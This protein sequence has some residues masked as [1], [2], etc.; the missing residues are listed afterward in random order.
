MSD[1]AE[2]LLNLAK[3]LSDGEEVDWNQAEAAAQD[4]EERELL[5]LLRDI[6]QVA[7]VHRTLRREGQPGRSV[8]TT[9][10]VWGRLEVGKKIGQ[11][12]SAEVFR[13][14][15]PQLN[16][17]VA[18]KLFWRGPWMR[19]EDRKSLLLEGQNLARLRH[20]NVV[21]VYGADE[22][23]ERIG[24]WM[25][26][27]E[28]RNLSDI[29]LKQGPHSATEATQ[30]GIELCRAL[31]AVHRKNLVHADIKA[32]N[33]KREEGG[34]IVLMDFSSSRR[35]DG[36]AGNPES[37]PAGTPLYMAPELWENNSPTV[38]S[39]IY[40][41]GVL[42]YH[43]VTGDFPVKAPSIELLQ[44]AHRKQERRLLRDERPELPDSFVRTVEKALSRDPGER[45]RSAGAFEEALRAQQAPVPVKPPPIPIEVR[46][47]AFVARIGISL[48]GVVLFLIAMGFITSNSFNVMLGRPAPFAAESVADWFNWGIKTAIP[49]LIYMAIYA[50][51]ILVLWI[52]WKLLKLASPVA[53]MAARFRSYLLSRVP[54]LGDPVA[55]SRLFFAFGL[56]A[57][58]AVCW[59]YVDLMEAAVTPISEV[60][61]EAVTALDPD[62][63]DTHIAYGRILDAIMLVLGFGAWKVFRRAKAR[64]TSAVGPVM[65]VLAPLLVAVLL[66]VF[67]YRVLWQNQFEKV[68]F[69]GERAYIIGEKGDELLIHLP[70]VSPLRNRIVDAKDP[71]L[72]RLNISE[73]VFS[74]PEQN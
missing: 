49:P 63:I 29:V 28:G 68:L 45:Y 64:G 36:A 59:R 9:L 34:R 7:E 58:I 25:E 40:S 27:V 74:G 19:P 13:A 12:A 10:Q 65:V 61:R 21:S 42:L 11:G 57:L 2:R 30:I 18:L 55:L 8:S 54:I 16:R 37:D 24:I 44:R 43:L 39:D 48:G 62:N 17:D 51:P 71:G 15:D 20:E 32:Q 14:R 22:H 56:V 52:M 47:L 46:I 41:L 70:D 6:G 5:T 4:G 35:S 3:A 66:W 33:V 50:A 60:E 26:L 31:A 69:E 23:D 53:N 73:S 1:P 67:P 72:V 38:E